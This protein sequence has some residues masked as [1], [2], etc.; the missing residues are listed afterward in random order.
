M[1]SV[2]NGFEYGE[3]C[4]KQYGII[5]TSPPH[6]VVPERDLDTISIPG[7]LG[8]IVLDNGRYKNVTI[9]YSCAIIS[10]E[11]Y[12]LRKAITG[13]I[14][15]LEVTAQYKRLRDSYNHNCFR[16]ARISGGLNFSSI[17]EQVG[18]FTL[19]FDCKPQRFLDAGEYI[20]EI[21]NGDSVV[22]YTEQISK[23]LIN[24]YGSGPGELNVGGTTIKIL[25]LEDEITIDCEVMNAYR[26]VADSPPENK[27]GDIHAPV[28][29]EL[30]PGENEI[31]WTGG[32][33]R[34]EVIPRWWM[35]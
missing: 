6:Y 24:I 19:T 29:P 22:N 8:D 10:R 28:F 5:I 25:A 35:L 12:Q 2:I 20:Q 21:V 13:M 27:N 26:Q 4:S 17:M 7:R 16:M 34:I 30:I 1:L 31:S 3:F 9:S 32:I 11:D 14:R 18:E 23:P 15:D 33:E